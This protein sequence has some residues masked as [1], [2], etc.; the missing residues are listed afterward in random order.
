MGVRL[1][2][3][4]GGIPGKHRCGRAALPGLAVKDVAGRPSRSVHGVQHM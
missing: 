4:G 3:E 1:L 2:E